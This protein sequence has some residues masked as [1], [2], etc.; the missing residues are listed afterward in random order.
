MRVLY[1]G[2]KTN[3]STDEEDN[4]MLIFAYIRMCRQYDTI[5]MKTTNTSIIL[6]T[7]TNMMLNASL[8]PMLAQT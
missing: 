2:T 3:V 7:L 5:K 6:C 4:F 1:R 8:F